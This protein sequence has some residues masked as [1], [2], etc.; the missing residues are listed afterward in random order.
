LSP[1]RLYGCTGV[2]LFYGLLR[3]SKNL[4]DSP[5]K[6]DEVLFNQTVSGFN[7]LLQG[8]LQQAADAVIAVEGQPMAIRGQDKQEVQKQFVLAQRGQEAIGE[9]TVRDIA[10]PALNASEPL[11]IDNSLLYHATA[12]SFEV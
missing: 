6:G 4:E 2:W 1:L 5:V 7:I 8:E 10:E 3:Q 12:L 11:R 9:K